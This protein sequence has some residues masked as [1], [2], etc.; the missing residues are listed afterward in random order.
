[1]LLIAPPL[2]VIGGQSIQ[3]DRL[4]SNFAD[5]QVIHL[6]FLPSIVF[7]RYRYF[8][9]VLNTLVYIAALLKS[10]PQHDVIHVFT[11][12]YL[13]FLLTCSPALIL[14]RLLR[15]PVILHYHDGRAVDHL[16]RWHGSVWLCK[17]A[18]VIITPSEFLVDVF[19]KFGLRA[20]SIAN[21][22]EVARYAFRLRKTPRPV[23]LHNRAFEE[24]YNVECSLRAFAGVQKRYPES[25]LLLANDGTLRDEVKRAV[26]SLGIQHVVFAGAV[27]QTTLQDL[28][29]QADIFISSANADNM[30]GS[31]LEAFAAGLPVVATR[32]G[33]T[34]WIVHDGHNGLLVDCD[35]DAKMIFQAF[36]L[37]EETGLAERLTLQARKDAGRYSWNR[38]GWRWI[39]LYTSLIK[40]PPTSHAAGAEADCDY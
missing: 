12:G 21:T 13:S 3:A 37:L 27:S 25:R 10:I 23:F 16:S 17:L 7:F 31:I 39:E 9:T 5:D 33:G 14:S 36:R 34:E 1:M 22:L 20:S 15:R 32:A 19:A 18:T 40:T 30:P 11:A 6:T 4:I 2:S 26:H 38:I 28:Y 35:D 29:N 24:E 8:R